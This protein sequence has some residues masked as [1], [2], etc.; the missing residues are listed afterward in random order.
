[1]T[2]ETKPVK[3]SAAQRTNAEEALWD[4]GLQL[5]DI[6]E[7]LPDA[8]LAIDK[9]QRVIIWNRAIETMTGVSAQEMIGKGDYAYTVPFYGEARPLLMDLL[10]VNHKEVAARYQ[11]ITRAGDAIMG[12]VFCKSLYGDKGAWVFVKAAPL[13]DQSGTIIGAIEIIRDITE[14]KQSELFREM[15]REILQILNE[16]GNLLYS[17]HRVTGI[18]KERTGFDAVG[19]RLQDGD[20]YPYFT[21]SGFPPDLLLKENTLIERS[22]DG[23]ICRDKDGNIRLECT[24]G[25]VI[26]GTGDLASPL[27]TPGGSF[28]TNDSSPLLELPADVDPRLHPRNECIHQGYASV[29]LV[30]IRNKERI[31]GLIQLNDHRTQRFTLESVELMEGIASHIGAALMRKRAEEALL[32]SEAQLLATLQS[33]ADGILAVDN[34]GTVLHANRR[35]YELWRISPVLMECDNDQALLN[36]VQ[37]QLADPEAFLGKVRLLY[38]SDK[39]D[40]DTLIFKDGRVFE[41][42]SSPMLTGDTITGRVWS[43]RDITERMQSFEQMRDLSQRLKLATSSAH[44]GVWDWNIRDNHMV[45]DD[46]M[47]ELYGITREKFPTSIG[48]WQNG[49]HPEDKGTAI[50]VCTA[51]LKSGKDFNTIFRVC[52]P[53]GAVRHIKATGLVIRG[54]DGRAERMI[55]INADVTDLK[56]S[57]EENAKLEA[58]LLQAQKMESVGRLAG[59]VAHDFNNMLTIILGHTHLALMGLDPAQPIHSHLME[60]SKAAERSADLTRQLLAFARKQT[61]EPRVVALNDIVTGMLT[62]LQR[63]IG[64]EIH[65]IWQPENDLWA[66]KVDPTQIDQ[67]L[68]NLCINAK[69]AITNVGS[70]T[71]KTENRIFRTRHHSTH[72]DMLPG[73]Y[74]LL[75]VSDNGCGMQ[76]ETLQHLFEPF[77]TTKEVGAGTGLGLAM[78]YGIV[79]QNN[80]HI[81]VTSEPGFGTTFSIY[82]PRHENGTRH[83]EEKRTTEPPSHGYETI[84]LVEDEPAILNMAASILEMGGY[85][86]MA[87]HTPNEALRLASEYTGRI[88]MIMTDVI[89]PEMN[90]G[91]L[92]KRLLLLYPHMKS[93]FMSGYTAD[94]IAHHGVLDKGVNFI[95][96]PFLMQDLLVKVRTVLDSGPN[97]EQ[98]PTLP[99]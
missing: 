48:V 95:Q 9:N 76:K 23:G 61:I 39:V 87:A 24:C 6:I 3:D 98:P 28:W 13:H 56:Q 83:V 52:H 42:Y 36:F 70:I 94:V 26:T 18:I 35:F 90:G 65:I 46:R 88:H 44:L 8:A 71:I 73:E 1:M 10:L 74:V 34:K 7:F 77:F 99:Q 22:G 59:G 47:F 5:T 12:E 91:D 57:E 41:R 33:T 78:V 14:H 80:G 4:S 86:V 20:D 31:V 16:P 93:L 51:A 66:L 32:A 21:Q 45:W 64:E 19:I 68:V 82:F 58:Q 60:V 11:N 38:G 54:A 2:S 69:D 40:M 29:A 63:L 17:I 50:T 67:I 72:S 37:D 89:M 62:M 96:K 85:T 25:L 84:L 43:F 97:G 49:L 79:K 30:P 92:V 53:D 27:F 81:S 15:G 55:G 75:T